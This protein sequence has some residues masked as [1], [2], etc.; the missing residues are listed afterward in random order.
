MHSPTCLAPTI[1]SQPVAV[2]LTSLSIPK[3]PFP[4][5]RIPPFK[6]GQGYSYQTITKQTCPKSQ[7][8][9]LCLTLLCRNGRVMKC[10][11]SYKICNL[12]MFWR[13]PSHIPHPASG[14]QSFSKTMAH[15]KDNTDNIFRK[16][17][18]ANIYFTIVS[19]L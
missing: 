3:M 15:R 5:W 12:Y 19:D 18:I 6:S 7:A 8:F 13:N 10:V 1:T 11:S 4:R 17:V 2:S 16:W 9:L 14:R